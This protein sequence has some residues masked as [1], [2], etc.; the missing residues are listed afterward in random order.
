MDSSLDDYDVE[1]HSVNQIPKK[2]FSPNCSLRMFFILLAFIGILYLAYINIYP[3]I[4]IDTSQYLKS[5][6]VVNNVT[7]IAA[8]SLASSTYFWR[9]G[10]PH[11][12]INCHDAVFGC[13][14]VAYQTYYQIMHAWLHEISVQTLHPYLAVKHDSVG[15]NCPSMKQLVIQM[16]REY[17]PATNGKT[18]CATS[19][20]GCCQIDATADEALRTEILIQSTTCHIPD[21]HIIADRSTWPDFVNRHIVDT[22]FE[23][24]DPSGTNCPTPSTIIHEFNSNYSGAHWVVSLIVSI[25]IIILIICGLIHLPRS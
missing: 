7:D 17:F 8:N 14:A 24:T 22:A 19:E 9:H 13:C 2:S 4:S 6:T 21:S 23:K 5:D 10:G 12:H 25:V 11:H 18:S 1:N 16:N 15:S 3:Y 20:F